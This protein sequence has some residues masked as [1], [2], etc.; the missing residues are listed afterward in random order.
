M[1]KKYRHGALKVDAHADV[2]HANPQVRYKLKRKAIL[3]ARL[4]AIAEHHHLHPRQKVA[5]LDREAV[6]AGELAPSTIATQHFF[7]REQHD[8]LFVLGNLPKNTEVVATPV[9]DPITGE[10]NPHFYRAAIF[11]RKGEKI[12]GMAET[13]NEVDMLCEGFISAQHLKLL[14]AIEQTDEALFPHKPSAQD[15]HQSGLGDCFLL[16]TLKGILS[17]P[18]GHSYLVNMMQQQ[19]TDEG[20]KHVVVRYYPP[21]KNEPVYVKMDAA[22]YNPQKIKH[23]AF[24]VPAIESSYAALGLAGKYDRKEAKMHVKYRNPSLLDVYG[25]GGN[26]AFAMS[27]LLGVEPT[28]KYIDR[29]FHTIPPWSFSCAQTAMVAYQS[30]TDD[31]NYA[32]R[33]EPFLQG[34]EDAELAAEITRLFSPKLLRQTGMDLKMVLRYGRFYR[35]NMLPHGQDADA[36]LQQMQQFEK[37]NQLIAIGGKNKDLT[38]KDA[39]TIVQ[40]IEQLYGEQFPQPIAD[41]F[42]ACV[43]HEGEVDGKTFQQFK[44]EHE[45]GYYSQ[46]EL[47]IFADIKNKIK[48]HVMVAG[49]IGEDV[50][51][52]D[53]SV[54]VINEHFER[55]IIAQKLDDAKR[56]RIVLF[57]ENG[58]IMACAYDLSRRPKFARVAS[59]SELPNWAQ[60]EEEQQHAITKQAVE[61]LELNNDFPNGLYPKHAYTILGVESQEQDDRTLHYVKLSNPWGHTGVEYDWQQGFS[62]KDGAKAVTR[63]GESG[64][65]LLE[66]SLFKKYFLNY[67]ACYDESLLRGNIKQFNF[68]MNSHS[69]EHVFE[70]QQLVAQIRADRQEQAQSTRLMLSLFVNE[71]SSFVFHE[72]KLLGR[73]TITQTLLD[74]FASLLTEQAFYSVEDMR[75]LRKRVVELFLTLQENTSAIDRSLLYFYC[76]QLEQHLDEALQVSLPKKDMQAYV[77]YLQSDD[78]QQSHFYQE[79]LQACAKVAINQDWNWS[80]FSSEMIGLNRHAQKERVLAAFDEGSPFAQEPLLVEQAIDLLV[81]PEFCRENE[82]LFNHVMAEVSVGHIGADIVYFS[83]QI[84]AGKVDQVHSEARLTE[85][86]QKADYVFADKA[87]Q[88]DGHEHADAEVAR[89]PEHLFTHEFSQKAELNPS[90]DFAHPAHA[91]DG[92][93]EELPSYAE[94]LDPH[95]D[96]TTRAT[97]YQTLRAAAKLASSQGWDFVQLQSALTGLRSDYWSTQLTQQAT[98]LITK[99][100]NNGQDIEQIDPAII[101]KAISILSQQQGEH[102]QENAQLFTTALAAENHVALLQAKMAAAQKLQKP[103]AAEKRS[104]T[105]DDVG[106][107]QKPKK[108][109]SRF[110][111]LKKLFKPTRKNRKIGVGALGAAA[112]GCVVAPHAVVAVGVYH[113]AMLAGAKIAGGSLVTGMGRMAYLRSQEPATPVA[114]PRRFGLFSSSS[115]VMR[116]QSEEV[117]GVKYSRT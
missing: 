105:S 117:S 57:Q 1:V 116:A 101:Q 45:Y 100:R 107:V 40:S 37:L 62:K 89:F 56:E 12:E 26:I 44:P 32:G 68:D 78:A 98:I 92:V 17:K 20:K 87:H 93:I 16:S 33:I 76:N 103:S 65:F 111:W 27:M 5:M 39:E 53:Y 74:E 115:S 14:D 15:I 86:A 59:L 66:L 113:L 110:A 102:V 109:K 28:T 4:P 81:C 90:H 31:P 47:E 58:E 80:Q 112:V 63:K 23:Q 46:Q 30:V 61:A 51:V 97:F 8:E 24:W 60:L 95:V 83:E 35:E 71:L 79:I 108:K 29:D 21:N 38:R 67:N 52:H 70:M 18:H 73:D 64:D 99:A 19:T 88:V 84:L 104:E 22:H 55:G 10:I 94:Y 106:A 9:Q 72:K 114:S 85:Q 77:H 7:N 91:V 2:Q 82:A 42:H 54:M 34:A 69:V 11:K 50:L 43:T 96:E 41:Y 3:Y 36:V 25:R 75:H 49:T 13:G 6:A 48:T